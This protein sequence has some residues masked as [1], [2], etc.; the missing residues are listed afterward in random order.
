LHRR[1]TK[2][3]YGSALLTGEASAYYMFHPSSAARVAVTIPRV[4]LI[5]LLR[6]P[7]DRAYSHYHMQVR[8]GRETL[9]FEDAIARE[10]ERLQGEQEKM[11]A[12]GDYQSFNY[13]RYS[14]LSRGLYAEQL[15]RWMKLFPDEDLLVIT[16]EDLESD[17]AKILKRTLR[18]LNVPD[19]EP[20]RFRKYNG[21]S[22]P[23]MKR[24]T[25][26]R[27]IEF[28]EPHNRRLGDLIGREFHWK[29]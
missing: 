13:R 7:V 8:K 26:H 12:L 20:E 14:Y 22:Y 10:Q 9:T 24:A 4:K 1:Y 15:A 11:L 23:A 6:N 16:T 3:R 5:A 18:F 29:G 28:F 19:W 27:M 25:R 2:A 17:P 21:A